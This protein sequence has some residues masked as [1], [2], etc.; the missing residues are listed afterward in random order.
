MLVNYDGMSWVVTREVFYA[1]FFI[2]LIPII[3][4]T[5][6]FYKSYRRTLN[7]V[8]FKITYVVTGHYQM[9]LSLVFFFLQIFYWD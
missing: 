2:L 6:I 9:G 8:M 1:W 4:K 7:V 3:A 5:I